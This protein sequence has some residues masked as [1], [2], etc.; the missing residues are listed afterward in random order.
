M[1]QIKFKV[2]NDCEDI[3]NELEAFLN[4]IQKYINGDFYTEI[5]REYVG[6]DVLPTGRSFIINI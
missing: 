3:D 1:T 4:E 6:L 5:V 2:F